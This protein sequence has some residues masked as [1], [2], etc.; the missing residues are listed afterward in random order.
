M[1]VPKSLSWVIHPCCPLLTHPDPPPTRP[2]VW[3]RF[4]VRPDIAAGLS[5]E[6]DGNFVGRLAPAAGQNWSTFQLTTGV[7]V[8]FP[9]PEVL[10]NKRD[11]FLGYHNQDWVPFN[12]SGSDYH[13]DAPFGSLGYVCAHVT[14]PGAVSPPK[15]A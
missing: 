5:D 3:P 9:N 1:V 13:R 10:R 15:C 2:C 12:L 7:S 14:R 4:G 11:A 8:L 6:L